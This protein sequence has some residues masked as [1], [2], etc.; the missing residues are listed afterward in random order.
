MRWAGNVARM[1]NERKCTRF[2]WKSQK[3]KPHV[4]PKRRWEDGIGMDLTEIGWEVWIGFYWLRI[5]TAGC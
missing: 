1:G 5:G 2:W 3:K 4:R